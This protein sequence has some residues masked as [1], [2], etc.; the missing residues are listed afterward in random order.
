MVILVAVI[1]GIT[2]GLIRCGISKTE[3]RFYQL[4]AP[5]LVLI[6]FVPQFIAFYIPATRIL[7][8]DQLA[9]IALVSSQFLLLLFSLLN[10]KK[11]S[12]SPII[13]GFLANFIV[14]VLNG[15]WMPISPETINRLVPNAPST[16][17]ILGHRLGYGKDVVLKVSQTVLP[18]L[19]DRLVTPQWLNY[20]VAFSLGDVLISVGVIWLLWS[21]GSPVKQKEMEQF[22]E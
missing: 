8:T 10:L 18:F 4:N 2:A 7:V 16:L 21:L 5:V 15:G 20:P 1:I 13:V 3:Y 14:I 12:F 6:A 9:S 22:H 17:Y 11:L 19:S